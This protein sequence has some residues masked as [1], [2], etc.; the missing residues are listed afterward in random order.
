MAEVVK[1]PVVGK[2]KKPVL[3]AGGAAVAGIVG[4]AWWTRGAL[5]EDEM[6]D[7]EFP[8]TDFE[9]PNVLDSGISVGGGGPMGEPIARTNV[10]WVTMAREQA[11]GFGATDALANSA[12][13]KYLAKQRLTVAEAALIAAIVAVLGQPPTGGPYSIL[14]ESVAP[15]PTDHVGM[16]APVLTRTA[17]V[18]RNGAWE[19]VISWAPIP[20]ATSY[21]FEHVGGSIGHIT[22]TKTNTIRAAAGRVDTWRF[23]GV[24]AAG[25]KG[26]VAT[27]AIPM[28]AA[29][30]GAPAPAPTAKPPTAPGFM[31]GRALGG[32]GYELNWLHPATATKYRY[33]WVVGSRSSAWVTISRAAATPKTGWNATFGNLAGYGQIRSKANFGVPTTAT[34]QVQSGNAAGWG[35]VAS[36]RVTIRA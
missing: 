5:V 14:P 11:A 6:L 1:V 17:P 21:W 26:P 15:P 25:V 29:P 23:A 7:V 4:Y 12:I 34:L 3:Y 32:W 18:W 13:S 9:A 16:A 22:T 28:A 36:V 30:A 24:S 27:M 2:V 31:N 33:R 20:G 10:E 8:A 19:Y 35:L